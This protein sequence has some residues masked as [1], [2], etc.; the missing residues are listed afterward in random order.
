M[1]DR[2]P[3]LCTLALF[4]PLAALLALGVALGGPEVKNALFAAL[5]LVV[6]R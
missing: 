3:I 4:A 2:H 6:I 1:Q 5:K